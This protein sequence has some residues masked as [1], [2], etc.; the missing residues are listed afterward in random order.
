MIV[1]LL[2]SIHDDDIDSDGEANS[3]DYDKMER[4][5]GLIKGHKINDH[6]NIVQSIES[7]TLN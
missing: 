7:N 6:I 3:S 5:L 4:Q 2:F 1:Y